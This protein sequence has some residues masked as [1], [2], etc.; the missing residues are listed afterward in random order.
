MGL[1]SSIFGGISQ[2]LGASSAKSEIQPVKIAGAG[3]QQA[4]TPQAGAVLQQA[5]SGK[6]MTDA[7]IAPQITAVQEQT[8]QAQR[9]LMEALQTSRGEA[10][11]GSIAQATTGL[12]GERIANLRNV[13]AQQ[14]MANLQAKQAAARTVTSMTAS[15]A[16]AQ[17]NRQ[18]QL[19]RA[20]M[21]QQMYGGIGTAVGGA[22]E[23]GLT[24]GILA[25][26]L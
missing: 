17:M 25:S 22:A 10:P 9:G 12:A 16:Q 26:I 3:M 1:I 14:A 23:A 15:Q 18:A 5:M 4:L 19:A 20:G 2:A 11:M 6:A 8:A 21:T 24:G 13:F 7:D